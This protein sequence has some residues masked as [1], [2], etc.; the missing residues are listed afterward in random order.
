[1]NEL[2]T[3]TLDGVSYKITD[4]A[5][6]PASGF[7]ARNSVTS[8]EAMEAWI[9]ELVAAQEVGTE[10]TYYCTLGWYQNMPLPVGRWSITIH[11]PDIGTEP[12]WAGVTATVISSQTIC[13]LCREMYIG[14]WLPWE[15]ENP[16]MELGKE[17]RTTE[18]HQN[19]AVY[20][21]LM[22]CGVLPNNAIKT[23][24]HHSGKVIRCLGTTTNGTTLPLLRKDNPVYLHSTSATINMETTNDQSDTGAFVQIWYT[25]N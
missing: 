1:M 11:K 21:K 19:K 15:W 9:D 16:P 18:R 8:V 22:D 23:V 13:K 24:N 4:T 5:A 3:L 7:V 17:Y 10:K 2:N 20:T 6:A 12:V 25:K 14:E